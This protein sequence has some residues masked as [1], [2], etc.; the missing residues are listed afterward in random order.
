MREAAEEVGLNTE[1]VRVVGQLTPVRIPISGFVL[2][3]V[4]GITDV[5]PEFRPD[6]WEVARLVEVSLESLRDE[7]IV[8]R[9][10]LER[11]FGDQVEEIDAPYFAVGEERV[12]GA[13]AMV[14]SEFLALLEVERRQVEDSSQMG[15]PTGVHDGGSDVVDELLGDELLDVP[16]RVQDLAGGD[17]GRRVL[18]DEPERG[19]ATF[20]VQGDPVVRGEPLRA[21]GTTSRTVAHPVAPGAT[22]R[23]A[24]R[25]PGRPSS[26]R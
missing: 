16:D 7:S 6:G 13:T 8:K 21:G 10:R 2:H 26:N 20:D 23:S 12:W 25:G 15:D 4:I 17:R 18:P 14:L 1:L 11:R 19:H 24:H 9:Q 22:R 3:P 5:R